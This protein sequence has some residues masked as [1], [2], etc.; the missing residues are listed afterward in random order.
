MAQVAIAALCFRARAVHFLPRRGFLSKPRVSYP[1]SQTARQESYPV[2]V[3]NRNVAPDAWRT[4]SRGCERG[5][6]VCV[7]FESNNP[8]RGRNSSGQL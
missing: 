2:G 5:G 8:L 1:G 3:V 4:R 6:A 7:G